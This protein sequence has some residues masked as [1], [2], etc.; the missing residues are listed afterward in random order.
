MLGDVVLFKS[1]GSW[2][3]KLIEWGTHGP[4]THVGIDFG[5]GHYLWAD[6]DG[7]KIHTGLGGRK[8]WSF[9]PVALQVDLNAAIKWAGDQAGKEYGWADIASNGLKLIGLG[10]NIGT[11]GHWDCSDFVTRYLIIAEAEAPLGVLAND[12]GLVSPNDIARAYG[13]K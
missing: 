12:P 5:G 10:F 4:Y 11:P 2:S 8:T 1:D 7:I 6:R 13:I 9:R 3:D